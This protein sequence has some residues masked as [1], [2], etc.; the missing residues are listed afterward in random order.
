MNKHDEPCKR[1]SKRLQKWP[2]YFGY[3]LVEFLGGFRFECKKFDSLFTI[4]P[5]PGTSW[6]PKKKRVESLYKKDKKIFKTFLRCASETC[7]A[8]LLSSL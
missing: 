6:V 2:F 1:F 4:G 7:E 3:L 8:Q 5:G